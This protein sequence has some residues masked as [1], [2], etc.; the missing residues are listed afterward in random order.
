MSLDKFRRIDMQI[1][2]ANDYQIETQFVKEGDYNGREL[3]VQIT[4]AGE[5]SN[6][7]GVSLNLGW[8]HEDAG[9]SGLDP[10]TVVDASKGI[11]KI[12]YPTEMLIAG[13]VTASIQILD[14]EKITLTRNFKIT[15]E[16]NPITED[17]I[18]SE[19]SFTVLQE[20]LKTVSQYDNRISGL[21]T[22]KADVSTTTLLSNDLAIAKKKI[23]DAEI[24]VVND[25]GAD[26]TGTRDSSNAIFSAIVESISR[27]KNDQ[28]KNVMIYFPAGTYIIEKNKIFSDFD[29]AQLG[30]SSTTKVG[31][32]F[33]GA[34]KD[35]TQLILK[36]NGEEKWYYDNGEGNS[37]FSSI[38][39]ENMSFRTDDEKKGNG[40]RQ[41]SAGQERQFRFF[42]C[43]LILGKILVTRGSGN[44]DLNRFYFCS[45]RA[46]DDV[47]TLDNPQSVS[48][49]FISTDIS[50]GKTFIN[51]LRGGGSRVYGGNLEM[52]N[53]GTDLTDDYFIKISNN[54]S[55]DLASID[56]NF[57]DMRCEMHGS[58]KKIVETVN[59]S[60]PS[61]I[62]F[63]RCNFGTYITSDVGVEHV[64]V[65]VN[66]NAKVNFLN[67]FL[68]GNF[69]YSVDSHRD[70]S[71][72]SPTGAELTF[73]NSVVG[74]SNDANLRSRIKT[75]G[76][77]YRII[78]NGC[79][80]KP[81]SVSRRGV[82]IDFDL[83]WK[84][85]APISVPALK[86][87]ISL[88]HNSDAFP[89]A[90]QRSVHHEF[91]IPLG[92]FITK[93][94]IKR[95]AG[96]GSGTYQLF[97]G[98]EQKT[99]II[100]SSELGT[101]NDVHIIEVDNLGE[102]NFTR[103]RLWAEGTATGVITGGVAMLEYI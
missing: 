20:A 38:W 93:I 51:V 71:S 61:E 27:F 63:T 24:D 42:N 72:G 12:T 84:N 4:N 77:Q 55:T 7:T 54:S 26:S 23:Y 1:N 14:G 99:Q 68:N 89:V 65:K 39:F 59:S 48:N 2:R 74:R 6:Q 21:E 13:D 28:N 22:G 96:G 44:A 40:F 81:S 33:R 10:F 3:V 66:N 47:L 86:K 11:F 85:R 103:L 15:V 79:T 45:I 62:N 43:R 34:G 69:Y 30:I 95:G 64:V 70:T 73:T 17:A 56:Y 29:F 49:E 8:H 60:F 36:T 50:F 75:V 46:Y 58:N 25:F 67:S 90:D 83:G 16:K 18:V 102:L 31:M 76:N 94:Y 78:A 92:A 53:Y 100:A 57:T 91:D 9:N 37:K 88:K 41:W 82:S 87:V 35:G 101:G 32:H 80:M 5:V 97:I 98:D 19:N 52:H